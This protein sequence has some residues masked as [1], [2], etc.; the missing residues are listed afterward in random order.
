MN[1]LRVL[2]ILLAA[3]S[4]VAGW[5]PL[6]TCGA[7]ISEGQFAVCI[8]GL[9]KP[10][11]NERELAGMKIMA[12]LAHK[13]GLPV[14]WYMKPLLAERTRDDLK[15][16]HEKY[17]DEV[18]WFAERWKIIKESPDEEI[19]NLKR[20]VSWQTVRAAGQVNYGRQWV[21]TFE[22]NGMSSVWGRCWE[23]SASDGIV[24]RGSPWGFY[25]LNPDCYRVP[26]PG[27]GGLVSVEWTSRDLNLSFRTAWPESFSYCPYDCINMGIN[28]PGHGEYWFRVV[29]EYRRQ[30]RYNKMVPLIVQMEFGGFAHDRTNKYYDH[31]TKLCPQVFDELFAYLK[32]QNIKVL[33]VSDAVDAWRRANPEQTP[34]TYALFDNWSRLPIFKNPVFASGKPSRTLKVR[35]E[36]FTKAQHGASY[37]GYFACE[38]GANGIFPYYHPT[39]RTFEEQPPVF[40]YYDRS[41]QL[42]FDLGNPKPI[43]ITSYLNLP[44][45]M[46]RI[47]PEY[48]YWFDTDKDI[49]TPLIRNEKKNGALCVTVEIEAK[50]ELPYGVMLWG[51]YSAVD[52]P[53]TAPRGTK[54]IGKEGLFIP[55]ALKV[56]M[57]KLEVSFPVR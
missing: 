50:I 33:T 6:A 57:N 28:Y 52:V 1:R 27:K 40:I 21:E 55:L 2:S 43:R 32:Q 11:P 14:T 31:L 13:H 48:S 42:F 16:W 39:G 12:E 17:G 8:V 46:P 9:N 47:V 22:R 35:N 44:E 56:G 37:N 45:K 25:Y 41:G 18:G 10:N 20:I 51:D 29:D 3:V 38:W 19:R 34:P 49:P 54:A 7:E 53:V 5:V 26:N 30:A 23:Q 15:A 36:R 4:I 24:D